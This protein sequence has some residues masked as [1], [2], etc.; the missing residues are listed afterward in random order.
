MAYQ[1]QSPGDGSHQLE[2][3]EIIVMPNMFSI[4]RPALLLHT[5]GASHVFIQKSK[6]LQFETWKAEIALPA[7][8]EN[9]QFRVIISE[10]QHSQIASEAEMDALKQ[11][12]QTLQIQIA[13]LEEQ[14]EFNV[15]N[16]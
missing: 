16:P 14:V 1:D 7:I 10:L 13:A 5:I 4:H 6:L 8:E 11:E 9:D 3:I 15:Q 12:K 2:E